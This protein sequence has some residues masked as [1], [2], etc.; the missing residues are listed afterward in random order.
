MVMEISTR[1]WRVATATHPISHEELQIDFLGCPTCFCLSEKGSIEARRK[2]QGMKV[3][4]SWPGEFKLSFHD[5]ESTWNDCPFCFMLHE[6]ICVYVVQIDRREGTY[7][8]VRNSLD[9]SVPSQ[10]S[11][12]VFERIGITELKLE[13]GGLRS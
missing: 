11:P 8:C 4:H 1:G 10:T 6:V 13:S 7:I 5:L 9:F 12:A 3:P 2:L